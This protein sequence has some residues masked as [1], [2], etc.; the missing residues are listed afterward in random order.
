MTMKKIILM[1]AMVSLA[2]G[3]VAQTNNEQIRMM[4][5]QKTN[6]QQLRIPTEE[7]QDVTFEMVDVP[8]IPTT[9]EEAKAMVV[10]YWKMDVPVGEYNAEIFEGLYIVITEDLEALLC[11]KFKDSV[12]DEEYA[13]YAGKYVCAGS[14]GEV[15][16]P[17]EEDPT[18][19]YVED[20]LTGINLQLDSFVLTDDEEEITYT[21]VRVEPFEYVM[22][23][24]D[25]G[26]YLF[27]GKPALR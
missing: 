4:V 6:G 22:P 11:G 27:K 25:G 20:W 19:F 21:C 5:V 16:F 1:L 7:I 14:Y 2:F 26:D 10:G 3:V 12:T 18:T 17:S 15:T 23:E 8:T 9:V 13:Q 24:D